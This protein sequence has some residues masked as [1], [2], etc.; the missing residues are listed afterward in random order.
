MII[1]DV[2]IVAAAC[3]L[4]LSDDYSIDRNLGTRH[5]AALG[6][7][8]STDAVSLI[9]SEETGIISMA[10]AGKLTRRLDAKA[11]TIL[12]SEIMNPERERNALRSTVSERLG[13]RDLRR[14]ERK[15][16]GDE[17]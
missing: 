15:E 13:E 9:V 2:R 16:D 10:S 1:R 14:D 3:I 8:E 6:I 12:L 4:Q 5:R 11:L 17:G 7:T